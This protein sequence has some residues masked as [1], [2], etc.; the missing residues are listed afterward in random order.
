MDRIKQRYRKL[1]FFT[2]FLTLDLIMFGAFVRLTDSG[3]GCPDWPGC[4][5]SVTPLGAMSDIHQAASSMPF[6]PV[7]LSKAWIE[8]IHRYVGA[9]LGMLIIAIVWMAWRYRRELGRSPALAVGALVAVCVQGA[10]GA[11]T[12]T[13]KLMPVVVTAHLVF[14]LLV[15]SLMTWLSARERPHAPL[16]PQARRWRPWMTVG[17]LLLLAQITLGGWVSTN[18]AALACMDFPTCHGQLL[19]EM[20]FHG[21]FSLIRALGELPSGEMISQHA[22]TAIHWTHRNFAFVVFAYVGVL[23]WRLRGEP[24]L[25]GPATLML[26]LLA[27]QLFTGLTTIFFQWPLLIAVLHNGGAAGLTLAAVVILVRLADAP[28]AAGV[29]RPQ[30]DRV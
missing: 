23:A 8:M 19:P 10:F 6:G 12:V 29:V 30:F 1:V 5:G 26:A 9:F 15:L 14:G 3:L 24:G 13:H 25:R 2:W 17:F 4:Y 7:T 11:W 18:Y 27:A 22:L 20:D 16:S 28:Q 21:G